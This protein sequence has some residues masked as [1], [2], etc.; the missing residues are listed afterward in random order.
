MT[1]KLYKKYNDEELLEWRAKKVFQTSFNRSKSFQIKKYANYNQSIK[2]QSNN[3]LHFIDYSNEVM[4]KITSN[5]KNF[6]SLAS[7]INYISR[8]GDLELIDSELNI[9]KGK[10]D[11]KLC[12]DCYQSFGKELPRKDEELNEKRETYNMVLSMKDYVNCSIKQ[13][14]SAAFKTIKEYYPN[15]YFALAF[16]TDTDNPHCH[17][18]LKASSNNLK[19]I[20]IRK[21]D[22][23][24]LRENFAR[25]LND[26]GV[27]AEA[28]LRKHRNKEFS[29]D[30]NKLRNSIPSKIKPHY[31]KV[32]DFGKAPYN[33]QTNKE[34]FFVSYITPKGVTTIW[35]KD[36]E[37]VIQ[38][39][40]LQKGE[41]AR[42][43]KYTKT[44]E[45]IKNETFNGKT[46]EI[47][48]NKKINQ[49]DISVL[50]R[51][52]KNF[53]KYSSP[54]ITYIINLKQENEEKINKEPNII[55]KGAENE[56]Y[57]R[58]Q[59]ARYYA[60]KRK[61]QSIRTDAY[62][63]KPN[64]NTT[65]S[66]IKTINDL[67]SMSQINMV[68][69]SRDNKVLLSNNEYNKLRTRQST[70]NNKEL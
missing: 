21:G 19:Y 1:K 28:T 29:I 17:I 61:N 11:N 52:E 16:H 62:I 41:Y 34:S 56:K 35:G 4:I 55:S 44:Q 22:I 8:D 30:L 33:K 66:N 58:E 42:F 18:C 53:I 37:R 10:D 59:W 13:L 6:D 20:D 50:H 39:S 27:K 70:D 9:F 60:N 23:T 57:T 14:K 15:N 31:Y 69:E 3:Q 47:I 38:E 45:L 5:S 7:H 51:A 67:H 68:S 36:L 26:L 49:W 64:A 12:L 40:N 48:A 63:S 32:I 65:I 54:K 25:N 43:H 46:Y 24:K 2:N